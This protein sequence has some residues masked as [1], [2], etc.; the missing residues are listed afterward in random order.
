MVYC[1]HAI[2]GGLLVLKIAIQKDPIHDV[3]P[4]QHE[5]VA[6]GLDLAVNLCHQ[7]ALARIDVTRLQ[8]A[9]EGA[10]Q[11][12][13]SRCDHVIDGRSMRLRDVGR[14]A[15]MFGDRS[16]HAEA[17]GLCLGW[18]IRQSQGPT[19]TL[20]FD[21]CAVNDVAHLI[22]PICRLRYPRTFP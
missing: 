6:L 15:V 4:L 12:T 17:Y 18:H 13:A 20:D 8:R 22:S 10:Q 1:M 3:D 7:L 14:N 21:V 9:S 2:D 16:M 19:N 11:S 5:Y